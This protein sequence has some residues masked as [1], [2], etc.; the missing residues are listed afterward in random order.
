MEPMLLVIMVFFLLVIILTGSFVLLMPLSKQ[1]A[2]FLD[3]RMQEKN[4]INPGL[5][6]EI[7]QLRAVVESLDEK[8][9]G[10]GERQEF[11]EKVLDSRGSDTPQLPR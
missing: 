3:F 9:R 7:Q 11:L 4:G 5:A 2:R 6:Q 8:V 10:V 1:L